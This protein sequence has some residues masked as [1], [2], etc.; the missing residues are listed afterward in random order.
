MPVCSEIALA[1]MAAEGP[2]L[3]VWERAAGQKGAGGWRHYLPQQDRP[4][5][6]CPQTIKPD[7]SVSQEEGKKAVP[8]GRMEER[9]QAALLPAEEEDPETMG[10]GR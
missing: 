10:E 1:D 2:A 5:S 3:P 4:T 8:V 7:L 9:Y 6:S